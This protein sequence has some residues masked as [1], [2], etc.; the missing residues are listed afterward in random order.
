MSRESLHA[1]VVEDDADFVAYLTTIA[2]MDSMVRLTLDHVGT[3][4]DALRKEP[5]HDVV[6]LDL[7]L[8]DDNGLNAVRRILDHVECAVVVLTSS[9]DEHLA[10][11]ALQ[12]GVQEYLLK[13]QFDA[14]LLMRTVRYAV[15]RHRL[16]EQVRH[17]QQAGARER[18][19][20]RME[21]LASTTTSITATSYGGGPLRQRRP[22]VH[23]ELVGE[24]RR[25]IDQAVQERAYRVESR[26]SS[27]LASMAAILGHQ[28]ATP[29]DVVEI[30]AT[31]LQRALDNGDAPRLQAIVEEARIMSLELMGNLTTYYRSRAVGRPAAS[32]GAS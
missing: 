17:A 29:R 11:S 32:Q 1:L 5:V 2:N 21:H 26:T 28:A 20:R 23:E 4:A 7:G 27:D 16:A 14:Q 31:A 3:V 13:D 19:L 22:R 15:E 8:P 10:G 24:Y 25:I 9:H 18:E 30:H 12:M 6:I